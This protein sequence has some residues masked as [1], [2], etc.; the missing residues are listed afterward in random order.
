MKK[1]TFSLLLMM[2][3]FILVAQEKD[4]IYSSS[5]VAFAIIDQAPIFPGC[6]KLDKNLQKL[7]LQNQI[8]L[9]V[10][11]KFNSGIAAGL[12]LKPGKIKIYVMFKIDKNG[13][14]TGIRARGPHVELENEAVR[15]IE[16]LPNMIPGKQKGKNVGVKYTL[17]I[18][19]LVE[20]KK[21]KRRKYKF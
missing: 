11:K 12:D 9:H 8:K 21:R 5:D 4:S 20:K 6:E 3:S 19:L 13:Y 1:I 15:T 17:P 2:S 14:V 10:N 7:C 18:T 16:L